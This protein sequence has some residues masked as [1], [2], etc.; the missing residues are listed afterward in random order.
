MNIVRTI[1]IETTDYQ[2]KTAIIDGD[3]QISY[4]ELFANVDEAAVELKEHGI[5]PAQRVALLCGDSIDYIVVSLAVLSLQAVI[6][7][8]SSSLSGSEVDAVL[9]QIDVNFFIFDSAV[10]S[11]N[12]A[13]RVFS[14][15]V[16]EKE[17]FLYNRKAREQIARDYYAMNPAFIRFSSGTTGTSK[18][19]VLSHESIIQ[20]T[21]APDENR[22]K[23]GFMA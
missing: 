21:D 20:R 19:V 7:P 2:G 23:A 4:G 10:C 5:K 22:I 14:C 17:F 3:R 15:G 6:V 18:G 12:D 16:C 13:D 1:K 11:R 8:V 9:E